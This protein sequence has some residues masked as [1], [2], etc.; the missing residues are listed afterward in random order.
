MSVPFGRLL[1]Y[2][3]N[4]RDPDELLQ[5][6]LSEPSADETSFSSPVP[7]SIS[8]FLSNTEDPPFLVE[9][10]P[11]PAVTH[12]GT[13]LTPIDGN[14]DGEG[15]E[16][17]P[18]LREDKGKGRAHDDIND[19]VGDSEILDELLRLEAEELEAT[20][21]ASLTTE[22]SHWDSN[23]GGPSRPSDS[24]GMPSQQYYPY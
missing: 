10:E 12:A 24:S 16:A 4:F 18:R 19:G 1:D 11:S 7:Q 13:H 5:F 22:T 9:K 23:F 20:L 3:G 2:R 8:A 6:I 14:G 17:T 15:D 21:Q